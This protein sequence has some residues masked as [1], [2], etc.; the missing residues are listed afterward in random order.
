MSVQDNTSPCILRMTRITK[1][2]SGVP[3]L[4]SVDFEVRPGEVHALIG[5]NGAGKS[6]LMNVLAGRFTDYEGSI[7]FRG[8]DTRITNPRQALAMGIAVIYQDLSVLPNMTVAENIML[9]EERPG[10]LPWSID[11]A[12]L[13]A[14]AERTLAQLRF[15]LRPD[16][17]VGRLSHARQVLVEVARAIRRDVQVLVFDEPTASLGSQDVQNLF[18]TIRG[19]KERGLAVVYISHRLGE[20]PR[21]ADR[22]TVLRD[23][24]VVGT[25][26]MPDV[27]VSDLTRMMLGRDL[28]EIF[29]E[30]RS[31]PGRIVLSVRS[32]TRPGAFHDITFDLRE[33]EIL[34]LAGLVGSGRTE[35][36]RA[37]VGADAALGTVELDGRLLLR[38]SPAVCQR[39]GI[40]LVPEDRKRDGNIT[41]RTVA[42]NVNA[43]ILSRLSGF[44][45]YLA[46]GRL[47]ESAAATIERMRIDPPNPWMEIQ[48]LSGGN[49]QKVIVGRTPAAAPKVILFDEPTQG[50]DVGTK[51]QMY[52]LIADLAAA[53]RAII[54]ISSEL[55]EVAKLADRILVVRDG[56][57]TGE[58]NGADADEDSLFAACCAGRPD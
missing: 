17:Q 21:I 45:G 55:I 13:Q 39:L 46:P 8:R 33:G 14:E 5:E 23:G 44:A 1:R 24:K 43:G 4:D 6:T 20:L 58:M 28:A 19:L 56:R 38:R 16:E 50:I 18:E 37:I 53:G 25:C 22:V 42:E 34:G 41:S 36:A 27:K 31:K 51:A 9:H 54:L 49:Q 57:I 2:F 10:R 15:D 48:S 52:R 7:T 12:A 47:R 11:R 35:I 32:L 3:A 40:C 26:S 30:R 29:P